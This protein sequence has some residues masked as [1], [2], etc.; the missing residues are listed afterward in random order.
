M[1]S[2]TN[3]VSPQYIVI[4]EDVQNKGFLLLDQMFKSNEWHLTK[5]DMNWISYT[6]LGNETSY[7]EIKIN[8]TTVY[9]SVPVKNTTF[10]YNTSFNS[11]FSASEYIEQRFNDFII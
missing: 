7:F 1:N 4:K 9:V 8:K 5:N 10:Q 6:K 3:I 2:N 11:Y